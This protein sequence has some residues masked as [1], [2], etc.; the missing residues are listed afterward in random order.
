MQSIVIF[1]LSFRIAMSI[2]VDELG[3][4][5]TKPNAMTKPMF[6]SQMRK[7]ESNI[8]R[9]PPIHAETGKVVEGESK[10]DRLPPLDP[11]TGEVV[12][13]HQPGQQVRKAEIVDDAQAQHLTKET[14]VS[15]PA[16]AAEPS[17]EETT[18]EEEAQAQGAGLGSMTSRVLPQL[19]FAI[20]YYFLI[21]RKYPSFPEFQGKKVSEQAEALQKM[22]APQAI[23]HTSCAN[24]FHS[25]CCSGPRAAHT[26]HATGIMNYWPSC[27]LMTFFPCCTLFILNSFTDLNS[28][29]GGTKPNLCMSALCTCFCSCCV[30]AQDAESLDERT[31]FNTKLCSSEASKK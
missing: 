9:L 3:K 17:I 6:L 28:R 30:I 24:N 20:L 19:L 31:G 1:L 18:E 29:L 4:D 12:E 15:G 10:L 22:Y 25:F 5:R 2:Q 13:G 8:G 7:V 16:A 23:C 21:V 27:C 14:E 26:F 11:E